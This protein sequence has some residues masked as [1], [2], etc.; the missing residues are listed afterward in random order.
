[1]DRDSLRSWIHVGC[2]IGLNRRGD[3]AGAT[4]A[5]ATQVLASAEQLGRQS[6]TLRTEVN[7][8]LEKI[9]AA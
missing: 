8:F 4:G 9:R 3:G 6:E 7:R 1:L 5:A 2:G